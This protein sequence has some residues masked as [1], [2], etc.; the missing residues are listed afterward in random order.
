M[1]YEV[2][3]ARMV[4]AIGALLLLFVVTFTPKLAVL[5]SVGSS[6]EKML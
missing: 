4:G 5:L 2:T 1:A 6:D 3:R